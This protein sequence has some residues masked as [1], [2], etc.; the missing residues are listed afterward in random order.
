MRAVIVEDNFSARWE[1]QSLIEDNHPEVYIVGHA[2]TQAE[3][4]RL[5]QE[6]SPELVFMDIELA[7]GGNGFAVLEEIR[8]PDLQVVF[9]SSFTEL[10]FRAFRF[11]NAL[12]FLEKPVD[13]DELAEA[14]G[15]AAR[16]R[17]LRKLDHQIEQLR[18]QVEAPPRLSL[19]DQKRIIFPHVENIVHI[20]AERESTYF[21]FDVPPHKM[22]VSKNIGEFK[23]LT[24]T[25]G[26]WLMQV[27]RSHI[28]G[29]RHVLEFRRAERVLTMSNSDEVPISNDFLKDFLDRFESV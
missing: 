12:D 20:K 23:Y 9:V 13:E 3:A 28:V 29:L 14:I 24:Q 15:R 18:R 2:A 22:L 21:F 25:Y 17:E 4:V 10:A 16:E 7:D 26:Q 6:H 11:G 8:Q 5:L 19:S 1:L 27:H